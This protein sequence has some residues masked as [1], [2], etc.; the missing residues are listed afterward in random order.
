MLRCLLILLILPSLCFAQYW[1]ERVTDQSFESSSIY[2]KNNFLNTHGL[3]RFGD[4]A[5]GLIDDS[6]LNLYIN[7]ADLPNLNGSDYQIYLD[8]RGDRTEEEVI[9]HYYSMP[10]DYIGIRPDPRWYSQ[11]RQEP[12]PIFSLGILAYP[13]G[14]KA[15]NLFV[16]GTYQIIYKQEKYYTVPS[17]IYQYRF[18]YDAFGESNVGE[19][20]IPIVDRYSGKDELTTQAHLLTGYL[21]YSVSDK[22]DMGIA[23]S[24]TT[25]SRD[26]GYA[27]SRR[28]EYSTTELSSYYN[29]SSQERNQDYSH[30]DFTYGLNIK[31]NPK[32]SGGV[33]IGTLSGDAEQDYTAVDTSTY[34]YNIPGV[35]EN[36]SNHYRGSK[37]F[38]QWN[39]DGNTKYGGINLSSDISPTGQFNFYYRYSVS[40]ID[41]N[42]TS[43][44]R[45]TSYYKYQ[46]KYDTLT[47]E[48]YSESQTLDDRTGTGN[49]KKYTHDAMASMRWKLDKKSTLNAG[50]Y[51]SRCKTDVTSNEPV[52]ADRWSDY[53][54]EVNDSIRYARYYRVYEDKRLVWNYHSTYWTI[55][56]PVI[57]NYRVSNRFTFMLGVNRI[58]EA[59]DISDQTTAYFTTR[60]TTNDG[61]TETE[62]DFGE[63]YTQ[64]D[65]KITEDYTAIIT[66][67]EVSVSPRF[68]VR[69]F[70]G[71]EFEDDFRIAQWWLSFKVTP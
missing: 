17:W 30:W 39:R 54:S 66:S 46:Y 2:F 71:P 19:G 57:L 26:G 8:F 65:E 59:W 52:V 6:H 69:L 13:F 49:S 16:G 40:D 34:Q 9:D 56:I 43:T 33:K 68:A 62:T 32:F 48:Y 61:I 44:I 70:L 37:R 15:K 4:A 53:Q 24:S 51:F 58:L 67:F 42:S 27:T 29:F 45:D 21:G 3:Y 60:Q 35:S 23:L 38:Q 28:D 10:Y 11:T 41:L 64:P 20:S 25:H 12:E 47:Y 50:I 7:P 1:G 31:F 18:G 36:W 63:R 22:V 14:E 55:Q 5:V